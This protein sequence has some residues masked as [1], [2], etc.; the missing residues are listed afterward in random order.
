[1][2]TIKTYAIPVI[3]MSGAMTPWFM[4]V[5]EVGTPILEFVGTCLGVMIALITLG[6]QYKKLKRG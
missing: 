2:D 6:V 4:Q 5:V 3:G 1:V